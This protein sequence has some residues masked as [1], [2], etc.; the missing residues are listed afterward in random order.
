MHRLLLI[1]AVA[2]LAAGCS[3]PCEDLGNKICRCN[4][5]GVS[6]DTCKREVTNVLKDVDPTKSQEELCA[7][8]L[9]SCDAPSGV[10]FCEWLATEAG[11]QAC[12]L[13]Y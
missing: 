13:A 6:D 3:K 2:A 8:Y 1:A 5:G 12:G 9:D 11:K 7:D 10:S 4:P